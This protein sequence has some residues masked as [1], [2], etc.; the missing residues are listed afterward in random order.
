MYT[1]CEETINTP[2]TV[3]VVV[4]K[5]IALASHVATYKLRTESLEC[6]IVRQPPLAGK[7]EH[8]TI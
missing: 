8:V 5:N 2:T 1:Q 6:S 7:V 4:V 3:G